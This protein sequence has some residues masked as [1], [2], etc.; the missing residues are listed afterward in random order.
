MQRLRSPD[1]LVSDAA[2]RDIAQAGPLAVDS[3]LA[4]LGDERRDVRAGAIRGLGLLQDPRAVGPLLDLLR[5]SM[6]QRGTDTFEDRYLRI[7][8]I[9]ALGRLGAKEAAP[10]L[11]QASKGDA[12]EE[13]QA[14]VAL[15]H[16]REG[17]RQPEPARSLQPRHAS[18]VDS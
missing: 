1:I 16:L 18:R 3:L 8:A 12:F 4:V 13:A 10:F 2:V 7:L 9:Q 15:F 5:G 11:V 17:T 14:G 6:S